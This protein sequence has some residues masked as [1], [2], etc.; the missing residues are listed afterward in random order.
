MRE[1]ERIVRE[2]AR[3]A[4]ARERGVCGQLIASEPRYA[5]WHMRHEQRMSPIAKHGRRDSQILELRRAGVEQLHRA[6]LVRY[7][8]DWH[9]TGAERDQTLRQFYNVVDSREAAI[10]EHRSYIAAASSQLCAAELLSLA[11]D[12][13][14]VK[15]LQRYERAYGQ[16]FSLFCQR[17][18]AG[19]TQRRFL[20][21]DLVPEVKIVATQLREHIVGGH[22]MPTRVSV[23]V[24][25]AA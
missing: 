9:V 11:G 21:G 22:L 3:D 4:A 20:L 1:S 14:G 17:A 25:P 2:T 12:T 15:L 16:Y 5:L 6:A 13:H 8:R 7:L 23:R 18:G 24:Q 19:E 10:L